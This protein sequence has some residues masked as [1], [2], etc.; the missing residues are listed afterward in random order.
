MT[1]RCILIGLFCFSLQAQFDNLTTTDDGS[2]LLFQSRWRLSGSNDTNLLKIFQGDAKG[3]GLVFSPPDPGLAEPP[4]ESPPFLSGDGKISGFVVYP[5]CSGV[6]SSVKP[7]L[8]LNGATA[9][10][11]ISTAAVFQISRNGRFLAAGTT[12]VDLTIGSAAQVSPGDIAAGRFGLGNNGGLL[13]LTLHQVFIIHSADLKL[14]TKP[15]LVIVTAPIVLS[16]VLSAAENRVV[17]EIWSDPAATNDQLWSYDVGTGQSTKLAEVVLGSPL[18]ISKFQPSISNDG[19]R[20]LFRRQRS[21][22]GWE[23]VVQD[24]TA[25]S[26]TVIAQIL[27]SSNNLVISGDGKSA[28][29]HRADGKLVRVTIDSLQATEAPGRHAWISLHEGAPVPGSYHHL[30]GGGFALDATFRP[31]Q[32]IAVDFQG[33]SVPLLSAD[34]SELD[35]QIP[36]A[37][38]PS[39]ESPA[40]PM[41]LRT[42]SSPFE[43]VVQLDL[44]TAAPTFERTGKPMDG[45][46]MIVLAHQDFRGVVT[47]ADP[48]APGEIVHAYMT[49][50][51]QVQPSPPT[52]SAPTVL[53]NANIRP[54]CWVQPPARP[55]ETAAV[56]FAGLAPG[57]IG[58]YQV[59]IAI[60][61]DITGTQLTLGCVDQFPPTGVIGDS[62]TFFIAAH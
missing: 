13:T 51:G 39:S 60:P 25:G 37:A 21:D 62:G 53:G 23:A 49:G 6:C 10:A 16:A 57:M 30:Y 17:Y 56:T 42:S 9:P 48:A 44:E 58:M 46:R 34:A 27:P 47:I 40:F 1:W 3:F 11:G 50:L 7:R 22:G 15:G 43:S 45:E 38:L 52:G 35:V 36:W 54:L 59:D 29:V 4:Y 41:T 5:G 20:L 26:A 18:G 32:D 55:Q 19:S 12:V 8:V 61:A 14:S 31:A 24:F 2:T 28:W 33:L